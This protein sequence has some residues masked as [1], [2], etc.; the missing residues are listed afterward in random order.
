[1]RGRDFLIKAGLPII[2][3]DPLNDMDVEDGGA[4]WLG[5]GVFTWHAAERRSDRYGTVYLMADGL[6]SLSGDDA[7]PS[8]VNNPGGVL[9]HDGAL[10]ALVIDPRDSTHVGDLFHGICP[11][12]PAKGQR[13]VLGRG[14]LFFMQN[15]TGFGHIVGLAPADGRSVGWMDIRALYDAHEQLVE[16][17]FEPEA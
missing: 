8:L 15:P 6:T 3:G 11:R 12:R 9:G 4:R 2:D 13:I 17:V 1:M 7:P 5:R 10:V 14:T 16:L